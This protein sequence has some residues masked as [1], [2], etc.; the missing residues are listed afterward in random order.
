MKSLRISN[1]AHRKLKIEA[2][3]RGL[4][5]KQIVE[6]RLQIVL[7]LL[8]VIFTILLVSHATVLE[9]GNEREDNL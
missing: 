3:K 5:I 1:D 2:A 8:V 6:E 4:T 9:S 7:I